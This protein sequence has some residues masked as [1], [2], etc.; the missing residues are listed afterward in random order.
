MPKFLDEDS[1][2][3]FPRMISRMFAARFIQSREEDHIQNIRNSL[4]EKRIGIYIHFPF[5]KS[6]CLYCPYFR[7]IWNEKAFKKY[8][9]ALLE[10]VRLVG[11]LLEDEN[12]EVVDIH[13]GGGSP[14]IPNPEFY[15]KLIEE[16]E[17]N[18]AIK[19]GLGIEA[20][21]EDLVNEDKVFKLAEAGISEISIGGQSFHDSHLR[22]LGR[23][24]SPEDIRKALENCEAVGFKLINLDLM[25]AIPGVPAEKQ[26]K[27]WRMDIEEAIELGPDEITVY[28]TLIAPHCI[29]YKLLKNGKVKQPVEIWESS[30]LLARERLEDSGYKAVRIYSW[31]RRGEYATV[32]LEMI[33]PLVSFGA[34]AFGFTGGYE[35]INVHSIE[36]YIRKLKENKLPVTVSRI[37]SKTERGVRF[38]VDQL[39]TAGRFST[40]MLEKNLNI[41]FKDLPKGLRFGLTMMRIMGWIRKEKNVLKLTDK[42]FIP[43][44]KFCWTFVLKV[45][46]KLVDILTKNV[47]PSEVNIP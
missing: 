24:H 12:L 34:G 11:D 10:E 27:N 31:S 22:A 41:N 21:P 20:C 32:N 8:T 2:G 1:F 46:C 7:E 14:S 9:E 39:F 17:S 44:H 43:A 23:R 3:F 47:W 29:G 13:V 6:F 45:P 15:S 36:E 4:N 33:G 19:V 28:P 26:L 42:G 18:F 37:V 38:L 5:C 40:T 35:W 25:C 30:L 16:L